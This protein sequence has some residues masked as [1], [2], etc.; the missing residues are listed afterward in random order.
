MLAWVSLAE[1]EA[2][3]DA[4]MSDSEWQTKRAESEADGPIVASVNSQILQPTGFS[5]VT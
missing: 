4:F 3:W 5:S 1:R 2:K